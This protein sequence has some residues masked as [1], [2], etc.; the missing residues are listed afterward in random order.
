MSPRE[1]QLAFA[2]SAI[3]FARCAT[4]QPDVPASV[5]DTAAQTLAEPPLQTERWLFTF[6][7]APWIA[8]NG[9]LPS[10]TGYTDLMDAAPAIATRASKKTPTNRSFR[11]QPDRLRTGWTFK[12]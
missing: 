8:K 4:G 9:W 11:C 5:L 6:W 10:I 1:E 2:A 7:D 12:P 3:V